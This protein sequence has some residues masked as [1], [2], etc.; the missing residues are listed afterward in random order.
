MYSTILWA[1]D[2]AAG[3][4]DALD[5]AVKL[6]EPEGRLVA[7]HARQL[8]LGSHV[9][10]TPVYPDEAARI[11]RL[12]HQVDELCEQGVKAELWV[13]STFHGPVRTI[14]EAAEQV[15]ADAIVCSARVHHA[16]LRVLEGSVS[17]RLIH[18]VSIPVVVVPQTAG[19]TAGA[20]VE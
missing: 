6:L 7:F 13:E 4:T 10:G 5:E 20:L 8:F 19:I 1:T 11:M 16:L 14:A 15:G 12:E 9:A 18:E 17:S 3:A 2:G